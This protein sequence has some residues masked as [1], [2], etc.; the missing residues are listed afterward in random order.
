MRHRQMAPLSPRMV[1]MFRWPTSKQLRMQFMQ[2]QNSFAQIYL[3][4]Q[5]AHQQQGMA[6][7]GMIP[8]QPVFQVPG[9]ANGVPIAFAPPNQTG[10]GPMQTG[11]GRSGARDE[12]PLMYSE[13]A[14]RR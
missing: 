2:H 6:Q 1:L 4:Q 3:Q 5:F 12:S 7:A 11:T 14:V 8:M 10:C 9:F 13:Q